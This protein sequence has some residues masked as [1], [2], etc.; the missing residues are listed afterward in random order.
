MES[1]VEIFIENEEGKTFMFDCPKEITYAEL[2][3][4]IKNNNFIKSN[5]FHIIFKGAEYDE[6]NMKD[7]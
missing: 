2:K 6:K 1:N 7:I 4:I 3:K 5:F